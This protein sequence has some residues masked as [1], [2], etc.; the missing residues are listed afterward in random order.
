MPNTCDGH[1]EGAFR[2]STVQGTPG[3][4]QVAANSRTSSHRWN[5]AIGSEG[6]RPPLAV[7][8]STVLFWGPTTNCARPFLQANLKVMRGHHSLS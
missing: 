8:R 7:S 1:G 2:S 4:V 3:S 6:K 5:A